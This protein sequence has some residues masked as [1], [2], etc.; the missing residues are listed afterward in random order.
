MKL[1][2]FVGVTNDKAA[3]ILGISPRTAKYYWTHAQAWLYREKWSAASKRQLG[4][5]FIW[6]L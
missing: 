2:Y 4:S 1:R 6:L 5:P 3:V